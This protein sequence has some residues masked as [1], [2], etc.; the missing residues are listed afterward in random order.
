MK[1]S[2]SERFAD[3]TPEDNINV[4]FNP[5]QDDE[6]SKF[7]EE[8]VRRLPSRRPSRRPSLAQSLAKPLEKRH[9]LEFLV[10]MIG[11]TL[12][13]FNAGFVNGS[14][15]L[16]GNYPTAHVSGTVTRAGIDMI[17]GNFHEA[18]VFFVL[19]ACFIVGS[20]I[21]GVMLKACLT[22]VYAFETNLYFYFASMAC[23]LQNSMTTKYSGNIIRTTHM[24][25]TATDIG[26]AIGKII[27]GDYTDSWKLL[28]LVPLLIAYFIGGL[29]SVYAHR[30]LG[31]LT[32][33]INVVVFFVIGMVYSIVV[34]QKLNI[35]LWKAMFGFYTVL[36]ERVTRS[37]KR[38]KSFVRRVGVR[39]GRLLTASGKSP[40]EDLE[41]G[42]N[43]EENQIDDN[44]ETDVDQGRSMVDGGEYELVASEKVAN[45]V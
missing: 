1:S 37:K 15:I 41:E 36:E 7:D 26:L 21:S 25:G 44:E 19:I 10:I 39:V 17:E 3:D 35:P 20:T 32:L 14:T 40:A 33:M 12:L 4:S 34:G 13:A 5:E 16:L 31:H 8:P 11:A 18:Y 6:S 23:G 43:G 42:N 45:A 29:I 9:R 30:R 2:S 28:V 27:L 24:T 22:A 38:A